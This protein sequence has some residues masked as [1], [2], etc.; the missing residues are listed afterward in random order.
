[1]NMLPLEGQMSSVVTVSKILLS[2]GFGRTIKSG[3]Q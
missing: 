1:M 3:K 2:V